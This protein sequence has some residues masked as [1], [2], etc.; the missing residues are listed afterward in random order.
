MPV[1]SKLAAL[2]HSAMMTRRDSRLSGKFLE[3]R[4]QEE[5]DGLFV[6]RILITLPHYFAP[7]DA[8]ARH[9]SLRPQAREMRKRAL[10]ECLLGLHALFGPRRYAADHP[11]KGLVQAPNPGGLE[12]DIRLFTTGGAHLLDEIACPPHLY[13]HVET[14]AEPPFLGFECHKALAEALGQYDFYVFMEDDLVLDDPF[15]FD[16]IAAFNRT[17]IG[18][19]PPAL[20]QPHRYER[21]LEGGR[22]KTELLERL[23]LDYRCGD[24]P[25]IDGPEITMSA[26]GRSFIL[27]PARCPHAGCF[28]LDER[29]MNYL[30]LQPAFL[31]TDRI[32]VTPMDT[33]A[34][35]AIATSF[36]IYKPRLDSLSFLE[37]RHAAPAMLEQIHP[38]KGGTPGWSY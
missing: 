4:G 37:V 36:A 14:E 19:D 20:L 17:A 13:T 11:A 16:K 27:E 35:Y 7:S 10:D 2:N 12:I 25:I 38:G 30:T 18:F 1:K 15:F 9:A 26:F 5:S 3:R 28:F 32:W 34:T 33:A 21:A 24:K 8:A 22:A 23:Y 29:Q 31:K 6:T